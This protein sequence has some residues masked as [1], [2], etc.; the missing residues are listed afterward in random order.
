M[1][2]CTGNCIFD[3]SVS[4]SGLLT[5]G[6]Q[7]LCFGCLEEKRGRCGGFSVA[8]QFGGASGQQPGSNSSAQQDEAQKPKTFFLL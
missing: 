5:Y 1:G 4:V 6:M 7:I 8:V 3:L 2:K